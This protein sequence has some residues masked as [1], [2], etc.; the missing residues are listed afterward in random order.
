MVSTGIQKLVSTYEFP[1]TWGE[2]LQ[3]KLNEIQSAKICPNFHSRGEA[4]E[5]LGEVLQTKSNPKCEDLPNFYQLQR[6]WAKV[7]FSQACVKNSVHRGALPQCLLG[8]TPQVQTPQTR[9][10]RTRPP[11]ADPTGEQTPLG[12]RPPRSRHPTGEQTPRS[13]HPLGAD[14]P[15]GA[16]SSIQSMSGRYTSYWNAFLLPL[17]NKVWGR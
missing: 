1:G 14:T 11:R 7:I 16:D 8:C 3:I 15:S 12:S 17:A 4:G 13:R 9:P 5:S 6:S 2:V 10:P